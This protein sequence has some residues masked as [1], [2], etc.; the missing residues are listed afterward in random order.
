M[1]GVEKP[2][3]DLNGFRYEQIADSND[4]EIKVKPKLKDILDGVAVGEL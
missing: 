2:P 3:F 4:I 1:E